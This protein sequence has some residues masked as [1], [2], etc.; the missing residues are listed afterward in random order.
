MK[1]LGVLF[2]ILM[3]LI[4]VPAMAFNGMEVEQVKKLAV[5]GNPEAQSKLG[6][7]YSTGL[8]V[9][10]D[11]KEAASWYQKSAD[12]G[13]PTGQW[14]LAWMYVKGEGVEENYTKAFELFKKAADSG[15]PNAQYDVGMMYLQGIT[16][17]ADRAEAEKWIRKAADQGYRDATK[18]LKAEFEPKT[19]SKPAATGK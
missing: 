8:G 10:M 11:K 17:K 7:L 15:L 18:M 14:N 9:K 2:G 13:F 6:V 12:Q 16:V 19:E 4:T 3:M 5:E 1:K